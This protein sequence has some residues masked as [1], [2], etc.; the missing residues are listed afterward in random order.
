MCGVRSLRVCVLRA[1]ELRGWTRQ[2]GSG[3][4]WVPRHYA[5]DV[6]EGGHGRD[7]RGREWV[8]S[9]PAVGAASI[10]ET[11]CIEMYSI[12]KGHPLTCSRASGLMRKITYAGGAYLRNCRRQLAVCTLVGETSP[13]HQRRTCSLNKRAPDSCGDVRGPFTHSLVICLSFESFELAMSTP[14]W[15]RPQFQCLKTK[16]TAARGLKVIL[17]RDKGVWRGEREGGGGG[18]NKEWKPKKK[19]W[20]KRLT[21]TGAETL[22]MT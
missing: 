8:E 1:C 22:K 7:V 14:K 5:S 11:T 13:H 10:G 20:Q 21:T 15:H 19:H 18:R 2:N 9:M 6:R 12:T 3:Q 4:T 17:N 16:N